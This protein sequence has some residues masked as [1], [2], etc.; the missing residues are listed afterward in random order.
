MLLQVTASL[1]TKV[2]FASDQN[3][4]AILS[5]LALENAGEARLSNLVVRLG[6]GPA[7]VESKHW[8]IYVLQSGASRR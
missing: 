5:E 3:A 4:V 1:A 8:K 6:S 7:F 2:G